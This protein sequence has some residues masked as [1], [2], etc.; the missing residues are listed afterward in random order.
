[1]KVIMNVNLKKLVILLM[2]AMLMAG[3][4]GAGSVFASSTDGNDQALSEIAKQFADKTKDPFG[5]RSAKESRKLDL[6]E[7][8]PS[9]LDLTAKFIKDG[10]ETS[11]VTPVKFQ[12]PFGSCWGFAAIAAAETSILGEGIAPGDAAQADEANNIKGL[13]LSEKHVI[14]FITKPLNDPSSPQNGEGMHYVEKDLKLTDKFDLGGFP[15]FATNMFASGIGPN[16]EDR[17]VPEGLQQNIFEYKGLNEEIS[18]NKVDGKWADF[19]YSDDDDWD[20]PEELRFKQSYTLE[21]SYIL[22][23]PAKRV[24]NENAEDGESALKYE[25]DPLGTLAIKKQLMNKRAV[26]IGFCADVSMPDQETE[27][28]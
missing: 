26:E 11:Y 2:S 12:N 25:Y 6:N 7:D 14:N 22:P 5:Y 21:E 20:M 9:K 19:C 10:V 23:C 4:F 15:I 16:R 24:E 27:G 28:I 17:S 1:M 8:I 18:Q 13:D 3:M